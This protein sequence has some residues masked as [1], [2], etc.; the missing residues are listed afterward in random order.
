VR[1]VRSGRDERRE[2]VHALL[3]ARGVERLRAVELVDDRDRV[4]RLS[5][6]I[7]GEDRLVDLPVAF[8]VEIRRAQIG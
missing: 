2:L 3:A 5:L 4:D 6:C 7:E 8:A 1:C